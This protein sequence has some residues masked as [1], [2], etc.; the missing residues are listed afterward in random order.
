MLD[1]LPI[2]AAVR[3]VLLKGTTSVGFVWRFLRPPV[4]M[5]GDRN[6]FLS[7]ITI[8]FVLQPN[9]LTK[10]NFLWRTHDA[11]KR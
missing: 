4:A 1:W 7:T 9:Q 5:H 10:D 3:R 6:T 11:T 2:S 8:T